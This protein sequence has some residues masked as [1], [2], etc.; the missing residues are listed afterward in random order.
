[1]HI[2]MVYMVYFQYGGTARG[3]PVGSFD[4]GE[5]LA[6]GFGARK[7]DENIREFISYEITRSILE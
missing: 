3:K 6:S 1:M 4:E 2:M 5:G 7:L